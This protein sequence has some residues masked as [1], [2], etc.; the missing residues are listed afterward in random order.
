MVLSVREKIVHC[1]SVDYGWEVQVTFDFSLANVLVKVTLSFILLKN[2][3]PE[4]Y[5]LFVFST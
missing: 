2:I 3:I 1:E 5:R 4:V